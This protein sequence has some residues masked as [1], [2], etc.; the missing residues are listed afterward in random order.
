MHINMRG[1]V[2]VGGFHR[3]NKNFSQ[4]NVSRNHLQ[5][6]ST[7]VAG[8]SFT[9]HCTTIILGDIYKQRMIALL[10]ANT[11]TLRHFL[12]RHIWTNLEQHESLD[13]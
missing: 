5:V 11:V 12:G 7:N 8:Q 10:I 3:M 9:K 1:R 13:K 6:Q 2:G 4:G